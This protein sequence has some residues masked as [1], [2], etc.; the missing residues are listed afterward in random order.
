[1]NRLLRVIYIL[2]FVVVLVGTASA[3]NYTIKPQINVAQTE[4]KADSDPV[5]EPATMLLLGTGLLGIA[6]FS[7]RLVK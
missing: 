7:R 5:P 1:M 4:M 6:G 2:I 3:L